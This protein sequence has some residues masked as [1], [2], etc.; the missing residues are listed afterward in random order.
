MSFGA[1]LGEH[2]T[3]AASADLFYIPSDYNNKTDM[4][5]SDSNINIKIH[6]LFSKQL[7]R[8]VCVTIVQ[9]RISRN[10]LFNNVHIILVKIAIKLILVFLSNSL[11]SSVVKLKSKNGIAFRFQ[12]S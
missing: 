8:D 11:F 9:R 10:L 2:L 6:Q 3:M 1:T 4:K 7:I 5:V 12:F